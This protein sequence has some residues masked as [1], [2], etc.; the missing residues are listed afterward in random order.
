MRTQERVTVKVTL[1]GKEPP[2]YYH[3]EADNFDHPN[4]NE[5]MQL[6]RRLV[7]DASP[8]VVQVEI[9]KETHVYSMALWERWERPDRGD[10]DP[11]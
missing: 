7:E 9:Y 8:A 11:S 4:A 3:F 1:A 10:G 6:Y 5:A 2:T